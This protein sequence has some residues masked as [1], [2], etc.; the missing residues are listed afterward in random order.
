MKDND[1]RNM[2]LTSRKAGEGSGEDERLLMMLGEALGDMPG[3]EETQKAWRQFEARHGDAGG[4]RLRLR[5]I[6]ISAAAAAAVVALVVA[7]AWNDIGGSS[8]VIETF[9][10][11][12]LPSHTSRVADGDN[13]VVQTPSATTSDVLLPDGSRVMLGSGSRLEY[14]SDFGQNGVREVELTGQ[15]RFSVRH[16]AGRPFVVKS[17][18]MSTK[19]L[20]TVFYVRSYHG[21]ASSVVLLKGC[22]S[23]SSEDGG[24]GRMLSPGHQAVVDDKG[25]IKVEKADIAAAGGWTHGE[26]CFDDSR[27]ED[28][29]N[30]IG[31]WYNVGIAFHSRSLLSVRIH[32][33]FPR[34]VSLADV[35]QALNDLGVAQFRYAD[36]RVSIEQK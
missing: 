19:V 7:F 17:G 20:G 34:S 9:S 31:S 23:V 12:E 36:G 22:V 21:S 8:G 25:D 18:N 33:N 10:M 26:F 35:L 3:D 13:V 27:L 15:A 16:D 29:M 14:P 5:R 6:F 24:E 32:F 1:A 30:D 11:V 2:D 4:S 28:V